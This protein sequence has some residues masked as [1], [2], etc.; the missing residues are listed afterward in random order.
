MTG[1]RRA[2][3]TFETAGITGHALHLNHIKIVANRAARD[4]LS[5]PDSVRFYTLS[6]GCGGGTINAILR[7]FLAFIADF[8]RGLWAFSVAVRVEKV[9]ALF[10]SRTCC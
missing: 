7:T 6:A 3:E 9:I 2:I 5:A 10:A 4:T 1:D 8:E